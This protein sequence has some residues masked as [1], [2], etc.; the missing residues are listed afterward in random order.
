MRGAT[1]YLFSTSAISGISIHAPHAG[2]DPLALHLH[3]ADMISI[4]APHA[5]GDLLGECVQYLRAIS[6]HAPHAGGDG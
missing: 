6:I 1:G 3:L 5:G 2:G 4:H